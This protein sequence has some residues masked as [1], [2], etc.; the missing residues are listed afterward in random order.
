MPFRPVQCKTRCIQCQ[1]ITR[2]VFQVYLL[3]RVYLVD[4]EILYHPVLKQPITNRE[5]TQWCTN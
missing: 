2:L 1:R 3:F 4:A 5:M